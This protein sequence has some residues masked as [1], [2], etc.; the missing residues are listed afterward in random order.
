[1]FSSIA[2]EH[3]GNNSLCILLQ[4]KI[5]EIIIILK[6]KTNISGSGLVF[7]CFF[8]EVLLLLFVFGG[9]GGVAGGRILEHLEN[10]IRDGNS[11]QMLQEV[12]KPLLHCSAGVQP[13]LVDAP[14]L[15]QDQQHKALMTPSRKLLQI[16]GPL[17]CLA[18]KMF[19]K[20][21]FMSVFD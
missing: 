13:D 5:L 16:H 1:M 12:G 10:I 4:L 6:R 8:P 21:V 18:E 11:Y 9:G 20:R 14:Q 7:L 15:K 19:Y 2:S 3:I 17:K